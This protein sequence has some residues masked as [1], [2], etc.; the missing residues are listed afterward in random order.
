MDFR[1]ALFCPEFVS[2]CSCLR[3]GSVDG[4]C[5]DLLLLSRKGLAASGL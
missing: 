4:K 1:R 3:S 2:A 5:K